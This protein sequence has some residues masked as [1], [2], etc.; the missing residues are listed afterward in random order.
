MVASE[1]LMDNKQAP[2]S[3]PLLLLLR[4]LVLQR[5][6]SQNHCPSCRHLLL[7]WLLTSHEIA[8]WSH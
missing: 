8:Y 5:K 4:L 6:G 2:S 7:L 1:L 3:V